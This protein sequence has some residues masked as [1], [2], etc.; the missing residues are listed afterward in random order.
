MKFFN[1]N[2]YHKA[3]KTYTKYCYELDNDIISV[4]NFID[5]FNPNYMILN[6]KYQYQS[7]IQYSYYSNEQLIQLKILN[8][9]NVDINND[10]EN[11]IVIYVDKMLMHQIVEN[12]FGKTIYVGYSD[13]DNVNAL[14][15]VP[16]GYAVRHD[17]FKD[18]KAIYTIISLASSGSY[19][20]PLITLENGNTWKITWTLVEHA[21]DLYGLS[22]SFS[23]LSPGDR[24]FYNNMQYGQ[25][26]DTCT[27]LL[28]DMTMPTA[29]I[30]NQNNNR[31]YLG[32]ATSETNGSQISSP[33]TTDMVLFYE[34][35]I[36]YPQNNIILL[37]EISEDSTYNTSIV[38]VEE[39]PQSRYIINTNLENIQSW[40]NIFFN[41]Y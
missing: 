22:Y 4:C 33:W 17:G 15:A 20:V 18:N 10:G 36:Y 41:F 28:R 6:R 13:N 37:E 38:R 30:P 14:Q 40:N 29:I 2:P 11:D 23:W 32:A 16:Q 35:M 31:I 25:F 19:Y 21:T 24:L 9:L 5:V 34:T 12:T 26:L 8:Y 1:R 7:G 3:Y 39:K 27:L